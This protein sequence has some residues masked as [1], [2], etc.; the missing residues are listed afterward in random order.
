MTCLDYI[1]DCQW[2][3]IQRLVPCSSNIQWPYNHSGTLVYTGFQGEFNGNKDLR[4]CACKRS[5][6]R[7]PSNIM[8]ES[9]CE[10]LMMLCSLFSF[11]QPWCCALLPHI[12]TLVSSVQRTLP[13]KSCALFSCNFI[14]ISCATMFQGLFLATFMQSVG[15]RVWALHSLI[16]NVLHLWKMFLTIERWN[17][18]C[19]EIHF[20]SQKH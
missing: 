4:S 16:L 7:H 5:P 13:P 12:S 18:N 17:S 19:F 20:T 15:C 14:I 6:N 10:V 11:N 9:W 8:F 2:S 1:T 3:F